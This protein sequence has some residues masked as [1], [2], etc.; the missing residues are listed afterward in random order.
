MTCKICGSPKV[1]N[2]DTML[3][4]ECNHTERKAS[5][6]ATKQALKPKPTRIRKVSEKRQEKLKPYAILRRQYLNENPVC[7]LHL[8]GCTGNSKEIHHCHTSDLY[9]LDITTWKAAC[10]SCHRHCEQKL[11]AIERRKLGLLI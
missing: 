8:I 1:E 5:R 10:V 3:C 9:F 6:E 4:G 11:S 7:E 2:R